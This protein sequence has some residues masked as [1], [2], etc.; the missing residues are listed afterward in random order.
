VNDL[1]QIILAGAVLE[2]D[3]CDHVRQHEQDPN[4]PWH[5]ADGET[6]LSRSQI[7][8][9]AAKADALIR[10]SCRTSR[11]RLLRTHVARRND[12]YAEARRQGDVRA[13]AAVLKDL[14]ELQ[15]LYP[16]K[17]IE[18]RGNAGTPVVLQIIEEVV[19]P[20]PA[21]QLANVVEEV[22]TAHDHA[23]AH[24]HEPASETPPGPTSLH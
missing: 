19:G 8:R 7:Y 24:E 9:Y 1:V 14:A 16:A 6:P 21:P 18:M 15:G 13:A 5:L 4:S 17:G 11:K 2:L 12:L 20:P 22:V 3:V 23:H 10:E